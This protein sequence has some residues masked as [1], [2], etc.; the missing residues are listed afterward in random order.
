VGLSA[1]QRSPSRIDVQLR[2]NPD[3]EHSIV[4]VLFLWSFGPA[5]ELLLGPECLGYRLQLRA[6]EI[7]REGRWLFE[8][9]PPTYEEFRTAPLDAAKKAL[10][11]GCTVILSADF[12]TFY[13]TIHPGFLISRPFLSS[14]YDACTSAGRSIDGG[15]FTRATKSLLQ[16]I[17]SFRRA[18]TRLTGKEWTAGIPIGAISSRLIANLALAPFDR[19]AI[20]TTGVTCYRRYVD[21]FVIV[22]EADSSLTTIGEVLSQY[23]PTATLDRNLVRI[24]SAEIDRPGSDLAISAEKTKAHIL[25]GE[26]GREFLNVIRKDFATLVSARREFLDPAALTADFATRLLRAGKERLGTLRV[27]RDADRTKLEH[28]SLSNTLRDLERIALLLNNPEAQEI[29]SAL[30][31]KIETYLASKDGWVEDLELIFRLIRLAASIGD[32]DG[33]TRLCSYT[34]RV[35]GNIDLLKASS[36]TLHHRG[37]SFDRKIAWASL[38]RYLD[39]RRLEVISS[40]VP[41]LKP[42]SVMRYPLREGLRVGDHLLDVN[43]IH[44]HALSL[45]SAD[46]R[47]L[48]REDDRFFVS[49]SQS[50]NDDLEHGEIYSDHLAH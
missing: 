17:A 37:H 30:F 2:L 8:Y 49:H 40:A 20:A 45:A 23:I 14:L 18:A 21:D 4:E 12:K 11:L 31:D 35:W 10:D 42:T 47:Y 13:D 46:L 28:F 32:H 16:S 5:L 29:A 24:N 3:I 39:A 34:E 50:V 48:D 15:E 43:A 19:A 44:N 9:W 6:G 27:L 36:G 22:A 26:A 7:P 41:P 25:K 38:Q 1:P 33:L